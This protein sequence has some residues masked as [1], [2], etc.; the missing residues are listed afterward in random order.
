MHPFQLVETIKST[1]DSYGSAKYAINLATEYI[2]EALED[3][4]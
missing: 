2:N 4:R 1:D 3:R